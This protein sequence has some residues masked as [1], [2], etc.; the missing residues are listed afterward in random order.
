M[1]STYYM[2]SLP[3]WVNEFNREIPTRQYCGKPWQALAET[4]GVGGK[5][6]REFEPDAD[7][8]CPDDKFLGWL[9]F[10]PF[11]NEVILRF[12]EQVLRN[13]NLGHGS[14]TDLLAISLS[15][16]DYVGHTFG[17]YSPEV[18]DTTLRTDRYLA[19]FFA[20]LDRQVGLPNVWIVLSA[21]HGVAPTP[22]FIKDHKLGLGRFDPKAVRTAAEK[23]LSKAFGQDRWVDDFDDRSIYLSLAVL[24]KHHIKREKAEKVAADAVTLVPGIWS[25][26]TRTQF[27]TGS[28]PDSPLAR[29][30]LNSFHGQRSPDIFIVLQSFATPADTDVAATHGTPWNYDSQVPLIFWGSAF[31]PG[32]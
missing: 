19:E 6:L 28:L 3:T 13:E 14:A 16:N 21:D 29:K 7:E 24:N 18:A 17:P 12:A 9:E 23:A 2:Q 30:A 20:A 8:A 32:T 26:W 11:E 22:A 10:T 31:K 5:V 25:A 1:S 27:M 4:P 15:A